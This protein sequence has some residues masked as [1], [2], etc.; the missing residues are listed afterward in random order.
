VSDRLLDA[1]EVAALL[2]VPVRW[3]RTNTGLL[4]HVRLGRYVRFDR[5]DALVWVEQQKAGG[6]AWRKHRP[7]PSGGTK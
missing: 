5:A 6:A 1:N 7:V 2:N 4:P 3:V